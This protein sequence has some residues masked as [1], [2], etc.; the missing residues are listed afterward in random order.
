[1]VEEGKRK[2]RWEKLALSV[3]VSTSLSESLNPQLETINWS[4]IGL[5]RVL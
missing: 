2:M 3:L 5:A 4:V 1:M